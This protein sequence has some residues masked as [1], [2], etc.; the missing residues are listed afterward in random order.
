[1]NNGKG[2]AEM[3]ER[4]R[5]LAV[6]NAG[7]VMKAQFNDKVHVEHMHLDAEKREGSLAGHVFKKLGPQD[8]LYVAAAENDLKSISRLLTSGVNVNAPNANGLT[9]LHIAA[10][11]GHVEAVQAL[12]DSGAKIKF[13]KKSRVTPLVLADK[14]RHANVVRLL[15]EPEEV[16]ER[17]DALIKACEEGDT[18][19]VKQLLGQRASPAE[20]GRNDIQ[21]LGAAVWGMN[22]KVVS[23]LLEEMK[24]EFP[25]TWEECKAHNQQHYREVFMFSDFDP[26]TMRGWHDL[27]LKMSRSPYLRALHLAEADKVWHD[28]ETSSWKE[29]VRWSE[30]LV[31]RGRLEIGEGRRMKV[32]AIWE[33]TEDRIVD[34]IASMKDQVNRASAGHKLAR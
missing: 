4:M 5:A 13:A 24:D 25:M 26:Q 8:L 20:P 14:N 7:A 2:Y 10:E 28:N 32:V 18:A 16:Q 12:L 17:Q 34:L 30:G 29:F 6:D 15:K 11:R 21:P 3:Q 19:Q 27:L 33:N 23:T 1:M 31:E 9:A 22:P